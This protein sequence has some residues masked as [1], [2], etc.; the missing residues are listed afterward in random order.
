LKLQTLEEERREW[1]AGSKK[2]FGLG[3]FPLEGK[4]E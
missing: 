4:G 3:I 1:E 2:G